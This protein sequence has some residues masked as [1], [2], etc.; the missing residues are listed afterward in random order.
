M[1]PQQATLTFA[2]RHPQTGA[3]YTSGTPVTII[4]KMHQ[5]PYPNPSAAAHTLENPAWS[6]S[7]YILL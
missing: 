2:V 7:I 5:N 6:D 4:R 3:S 1:E